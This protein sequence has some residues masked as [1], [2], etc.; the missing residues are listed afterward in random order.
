M[1]QTTNQMIATFDRVIRNG[2]SCADQHL[3]Y[4]AS[5]A[6]NKALIDSVAGISPAETKGFE[7]IESFAPY[8]EMPAFCVGFSDRYRDREHSGAD[9]TFSGVDMQAYDRGLMAASL[10]LR[11]GL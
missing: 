3:R 2:Q 10:C 4:P 6:R 8:H 5:I 11:L 7:E 9:Y 1:T